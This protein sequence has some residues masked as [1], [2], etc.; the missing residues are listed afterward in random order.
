MK[1]FNSSTVCICEEALP[2]PQEELSPCCFL[3]NMIKAFTHWGRW[4]QADIQG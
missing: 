2:N 4:T 1:P 3:V